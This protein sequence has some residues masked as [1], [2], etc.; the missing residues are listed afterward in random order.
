MKDRTFLRGVRNGI[1]IALGYLSVSFSFGIMAAAQCMTVWQ[2]VLISL[3][4]VTSA[5]QLAGLQI[6]QSPG[7]YMAML[8]SQL[9]INLRYAFMGI[10]LSQKTDERFT[11][12]YRWLLA[13]FITDEIFAMACAEESVSARYYAGLAVLPYTGWALGTLMGAVLGNILPTMVMNALCIAMYGMFVAIVAPRVKEE[14]RLFWVVLFAAALMCVCHYLIPAL[15][16]GLAISLCAVAAALFG[17]L[18]F[19]IAGK[20]DME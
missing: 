20:E 13:T 17:A 12:K 15:S 9:T 1:P 19:P 10:S 16:A 11:G 4:S 18:C 6:M 14:H 8:L 5:G 7:Q 2:A 3:L